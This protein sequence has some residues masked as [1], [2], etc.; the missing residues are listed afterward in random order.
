MHFIENHNC[1][2][3]PSSKAAAAA[4][5]EEDSADAGLAGMEDAWGCLSLGRGS[6]P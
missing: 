5:E 2:L 1:T 3:S 6:A 4:S